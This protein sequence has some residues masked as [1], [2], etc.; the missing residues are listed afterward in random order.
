MARPVERAFGRRVRE[1]RKALGWTLDELV[2]NCGLTKAFLS[3]IENGKRGIG[4]GN[5]VELCRALKVSMPS[6]IKQPYDYGACPHCKGRVV[7]RDR[8]SKNDT[9]ENKHVFP[10]KA[11]LNE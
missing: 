2:E 7:L 1:R 11:T 3:D 6:M 10:I 5:A 9:C 8:K 4:L